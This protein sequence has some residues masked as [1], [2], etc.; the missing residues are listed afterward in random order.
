MLVN[1]AGIQ[2]PSDSHDTTAAEFDKVLGV[3]LRGAFL[4]AKEAI[5]HFLEA[6]KPGVII[7][8]SSVHQII[9]KP[10]F[11]GYSVSKGGMQNLTRTLALEY[12]AQG[13][14]VNAIGPGYFATELTRPLVEDEKFNTWSCGRTPA[15]RWGRPEELIGAAVYFA[16][17]ASSFVNGQFLY[18]DG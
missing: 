15:N 12:A 1:N 14:R 7:N 11:V 17:P 5:E 16:S 9:P 2:I 3:N 4:C 6:E 8:V 13:I 10:R 18:V